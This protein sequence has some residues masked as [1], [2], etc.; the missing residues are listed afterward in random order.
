MF[1]IKFLPARF[2]DA[3]WI[4]Y[5]DALAPHRLLID[6]GTAGTCQDIKAL[7]Q[8]VPA[9]QRRF[10]LIVISHVDRDHIE[11]ILG[12]LKQDDLGIE[13]GD[14]WFNGWPHL[15]GNS[16]AEHFGAIQGERLSRILLDHQFPWNQ[17]FNREAIYIPENGPLPKRNLPG[18]MQLTLL[19]P[20][21]D[22]LAKLKPKWEQEVREANLDPG[23]GLVE[24]DVDS[25]EGDTE[26]FGAGDLPDLELLAATEF[27]EDES[28]ANG[29]SLAFLVEFENKRVILAADAHCG[30]LLS[31]LHR[32]FPGERIS[33]D[34]FKLSHHGSKY[35]TSRALIEKVDC[36]AYV[37]STNGSIFKHPDPE[38]V[39]RVIMTAGGRPELIFNYRTARNEIWDLAHLKNKYG[40]VTQYPTAPKQGIE[41]S[42]LF[43]G[44]VF[45]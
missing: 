9:G 6:G 13:I 8:S 7:L 5:G 27:E 4:E 40:Y 24:N 23:F 29:S 28:E 15:P 37:F 21:L 44:L 32:H 11:G 1:T 19:S 3:V 20:S 12:L 14:V 43:D 10:E 30:V 18:G 22:K 17:S 41:I 36:P 33:L 16:N 26:E 31:A 39:A 38:T 45:S 2:G 34:L 35:T 25:A 42:L